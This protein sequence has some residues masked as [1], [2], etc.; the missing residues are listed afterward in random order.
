[1]V[2][3]RL[4]DMLGDFPHVSTLAYAGNLD[5]ARRY[6]PVFEPHLL[7]LDICLPDGNGL[8]LLKEVR[9]TELDTRVA[10]FS[11]NLEFMQ[12]SLD[13]GAD[14]YFDKTMEFPQLLS[15]LK[16]RTY[17]Q[18]REDEARRCGHVGS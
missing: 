2:W 9:V 14:W 10:V 15:L 17:W 1:M 11:N 8:E 18:G 5:E 3:K 6:L 4:F 16:D 13:L 7:V 12:L